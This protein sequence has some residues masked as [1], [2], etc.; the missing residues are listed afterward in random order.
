MP[1]IPPGKY[2]L[3]VNTQIQPFLLGLVHV[4]PFPRIKLLHHVRTK[5]EAKNPVF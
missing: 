3:K 5:D 2:L 4:L 1:M